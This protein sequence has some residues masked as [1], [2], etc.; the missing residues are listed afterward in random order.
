MNA[1]EL[2]DRLDFYV[3]RVKSVR[4]DDTD[5]ATATNIAIAKIVD[6]RYDN[7]KKKRSYSFQSIQAIRDELYTIV[8]TTPA[9]AP[10]NNIF[11][12]PA[13]YRHEVAFNI[14]IDGNEVASHSSSY[15]EQGELKDYSFANPDKN[16]PVHNEDENGINIYFNGGGTISTAKLSYIRN[17]AIVLVSD[18]IISQG[19]AVLT[20]G[21]TYYVVTAPMVHNSVTYIVGQTFVAVNTAFTGAGTVELI[22]NCDLPTNMHDEVASTAAQILLGIAT[23][24][25]GKQNMKDESDRA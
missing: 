18:T 23:N 2:F 16:E 17:P 21:Q 11:S 20:I 8:K 7:F 19:P 9:I 13:D 1:V 14:I 3:D 15:E 25:N 5:R 10:V 12:Y 22:V 24:Y 6:D 4:Y